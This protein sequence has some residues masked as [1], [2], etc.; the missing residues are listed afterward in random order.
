MH[1]GSL[2]P[3]A[4][5]AEGWLK[6]RASGG[7]AG[8]CVSIKAVSDR[9]LVIGDSKARREQGYVAHFEPVIVVSAVGYERFREALASSD[10][11]RPGS[12]VE[13]AE[14]IA[15]R[16][17]NGTVRVTSAADSTTLEFLPA[18]WDA[19]LRAIRDNELRLRDL[20]EA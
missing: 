2:G 3:T 17:G 15:E 9:T 11:G 6:A 16:L 18:E 4:V 7:G 14:V 12:I 8:C 5:Q 13:T 20:V 1:L 19:Y 10:T